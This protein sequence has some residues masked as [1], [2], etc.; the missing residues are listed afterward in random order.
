MTPHSEIID[1]HMHTTVSDGTETP[2]QIS[3]SV[4]EAG[5]GLFSVTDHDDTRGSCRIL[6][7]IVAGETG[8]PPFITGVEFS[9]KDAQLREYHILGYG[10][11][12]SAGAVLNL[13][14]KAHSFRIQKVLLRLEFLEEEYGFSFPA[15]ELE[16]LFSLD[17][18]GKP[19]IGNLMVKYGYAP[20]KDSAILD[21]INKKKIP[22]VYLT[23]E[24]AI[25]GIL[26][27]GGIPILA[28]PAFGSGEQRLNK[29]ELEERVVRLTETGLRGIEA[30]YSV[31]TDEAV[32]MHLD[33]A[34]KYGLYVTAGSDYHGTNKTV[35]LGDTPLNRAAAAAEGL[36]RFLEEVTI[37]QNRS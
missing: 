33:L 18:P 31:F 4:R 25:Q 36:Q 35:I 22:D 14:R 28:H 27:S 26:E 8:I 2:E 20:S 21:Y 29:E 11:D 24:E 9:C 23:P 19:H 13:T 7:Q 37:Q 3:G 12:V 15:E 30:Y 32:R 10:Y 6:E 5:I 17:N 34:E 1:L 16:T